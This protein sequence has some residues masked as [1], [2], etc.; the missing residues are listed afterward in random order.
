MGVA[1]TLLTRNSQAQLRDANRTLRNSFMLLNYVADKGVA[2]SV[3][4]PKGSTLWSTSICKQWASAV[5][6][7]TYD[8]DMCAFGMPFRKSTRIMASGDLNLRG[9]DMFQCTGDHEHVQLSGWVQ[10]HKKNPNILL[11]TKFGNPIP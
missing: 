11:P 9:F 5:D 4:N 1:R 7:R 3:E 6:A 8:F 2:A 10:R